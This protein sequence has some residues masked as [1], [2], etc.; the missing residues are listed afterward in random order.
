[1]PWRLVRRFAAVCRRSQST[2][3]RVVTAA[4]H[5]PVPAALVSHTDRR[6]REWGAGRV[7]SGRLRVSVC[8]ARPPDPTIRLPLLCWR[9]AARPVKSR[10]RRRPLSSLSSCWQR[11]GASTGCGCYLVLLRE[12]MLEHMCVNVWRMLRSRAAVGGFG[13]LYV[14]SVISEG[15]RVSCVRTGRRAVRP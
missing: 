10:A 15:C 9:T 4:H 2:F 1:M 5:C 14:W 8:P 11:R 13:R 6:A 3:G 12:Q 7:P